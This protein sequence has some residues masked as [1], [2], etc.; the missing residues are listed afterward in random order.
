M[1]LPF[2][3]FE[4]SGK[5]IAEALAKPVTARPAA[6]QGTRPIHKDKYFFS[7]HE[8]NYALTLYLYLSMSSQIVINE[9]PPIV[10]WKEKMSILMVTFVMVGVWLISIPIV[11]YFNGKIPLNDFMQIFVSI[12]IFL[13]GSLLTYIGMSSSFITLYFK[14]QSLIVERQIGFFRFYKKYDLSNNSLI[15]IENEEDEDG[16]TWYHLIKIQNDTK[17]YIL[18]NLDTK[19][20]E[21][22]QNL[23]HS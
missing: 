8:L 9:N 7:F 10:K 19:Y 20:Y 16:I 1:A 22:I 11:G 4:K 23:I 18:K 21:A 5:R 17:T 15:K 2:D 13:L 14:N 6:K 12:N 3:A